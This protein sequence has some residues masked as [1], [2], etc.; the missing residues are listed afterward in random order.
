MKFNFFIAAMALS[1]VTFAQGDV[2][3]T[4]PQNIWEKKVAVFKVRNH[5]PDETGKEMTMTD[6]CVVIRPGKKKPEVILKDSTEAITRYLFYNAKGNL[7]CDSDA[8]GKYTQK[9]RY[10]KQ[11]RIIENIRKGDNTD[12]IKWIREKD[13]VFCRR[14]YKNLI[15]F[16]MLEN[17]QHRQVKLLAPSK[18]GLWLYSESKYDE[19]GFL[20]DEIYYVFP[21]GEVWL[22]YIYKTGKQGLVTNMECSGPKEPKT[23]CE[24]E[25]EFYK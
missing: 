20:T 2:G 3:L 22:H 16:K 7:I 8:Q 12:T 4:I 6:I 10:D 13:T 14:T 24:Y 5:F 11:G 9:F 15:Y 1:T 23:T 17:K 25:Y 18:K 19:T 21:T